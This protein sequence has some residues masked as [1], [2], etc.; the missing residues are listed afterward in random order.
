M[1]FD[2]RP[3]LDLRSGDGQ[4]YHSENVRPDMFE[5]CTFEAARETLIDYGYNPPDDEQMRQMVDPGSHG[6]EPWSVSRL[7]VMRI[8]PDLPTTIEGPVDVVAALQQYGQLGYAVHIAFWCDT[9]ANIPPQNYPSGQLSHAEVLIY[10]TGSALGFKNVWPHPDYQLTYD[11]VRQLY[12]GGGILVFKRALKPGGFMSDQTTFDTFVD[13]NPHLAQTDVRTQ[14]M[15]VEQH[16]IKAGVDGLIA[17]VAALPGKLVVP[18]PVVNVTVPASAYQPVLDAVTA[19]AAK[20]DAR[21]V[22]PPAP[23]APAA[24]ATPSV[25]PGWGALLSELLRRVLGKS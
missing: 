22:T 18:A 8:A 3:Y 19:L 15:Q 12:D 9:Q 23:V 14:E 24:P 21:P 16:D 20:V 1:A 11:Q 4:L 10:D 5:A 7:A 6:G 17:A 2:L 25:D 13:H